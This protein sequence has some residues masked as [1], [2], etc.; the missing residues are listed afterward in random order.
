MN[1]EQP[2]TPETEILDYLKQ[3]TGT[4]FRP[5]KSNL[6]LISAL[7]KAGYE[8]EEIIEVIQLKTVQW[9]NNAVMAPYL[10][11]STLFKMSNFDNYVNE[12]ELV[13]QNPKMYAQHFAAL[14]KIKGSRSAADDTDAI[15]DLYG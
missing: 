1:K 5:I 4:K 8:Q 3:V 9:K 12:L 14:N 10:R 11:P 2:Q 6:T 15:S 7:L 13:K